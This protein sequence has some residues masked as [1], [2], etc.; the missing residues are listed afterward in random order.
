[1]VCSFCGTWLKVSSSSHPSTEYLMHL[2]RET[3][4]AWEFLQ[5]LHV[6]SPGAAEPALPPS[7]LGHTTERLLPMSS[8]GVCSCSAVLQVTFLVTLQGGSV[9]QHSWR[10]PAASLKESPCPCS[11]R[12]QVI[13]RCLSAPMLVGKN[14]ACCRTEIPRTW[15]KRGQR[16]FWVG[17]TGTGA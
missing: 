3:P 16:L 15:L 2:L 7:F 4:G 11:Q 14:S 1:M 12:K 9:L 5:L 17:S 6:P 13:L 10:E 8:L